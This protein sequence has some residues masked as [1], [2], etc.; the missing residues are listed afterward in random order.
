MINIDDR[1]KHRNGKISPCDPSVAIEI[2]K[3]IESKQ[4]WETVLISRQSNPR[5]SEH[6]SKIAKAHCALVVCVPAI[7]NVVGVD[8]A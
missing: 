5:M 8:K 1:F 3:V 7:A 6:E 4:L 2:Q